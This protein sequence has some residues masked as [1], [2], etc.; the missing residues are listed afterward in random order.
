MLIEMWICQP[1]EPETKMQSTHL[2]MVRLYLNHWEFCHWFLKGF[3]FWGIEVK[4]RI[5]YHPYL[6]FCL[7]LTHWNLVRWALISSRCLLTQASWSSWNAEFRGT[8]CHHEMAWSNSTPT[9]LE[10][11]CSDNAVSW[12]AGP[13]WIDTQKGMMN[14]LNRC[15]GWHTL[16]C[17]NNAISW[18]NFPV[19]MLL[20]R[21]LQLMGE[22]LRAACSPP[23]EL[24]HPSPFPCRA[25]FCL[26]QRHPAPP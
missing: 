8:P 5:A 22:K 4:F 21:L 20:F 23:P 6:G 9:L 17:N 10:L 7:A 18:H 1:Q 11:Y 26:S 2:V 24:Y 15:I 25:L 19:L 14:Q 16:G 12:G 3:R 13:G